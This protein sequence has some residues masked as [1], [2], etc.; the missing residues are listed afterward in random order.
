M[1]VPVRTCGIMVE[2]RLYQEKVNVDMLNTIKNVLAD[3]L[4]IA[5]GQRGNNCSDE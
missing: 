5:L 1:L 2:H 3:V 4:S